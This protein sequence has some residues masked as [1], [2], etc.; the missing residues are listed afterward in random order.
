VASFKQEANTS[1]NEDT[2]HHGETLLVISTCDSEDV[3]FEFITQSVSSHL[4]GHALV[5]ENAQ[6]LLI[7]Y[8]DGFARSRGWVGYD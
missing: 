3:A 7:F 4:L 2:L 8:F 1:L 5:I 6:F